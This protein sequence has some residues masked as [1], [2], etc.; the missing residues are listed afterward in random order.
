MN[1]S[2]TRLLGLGLGLSL[3]LLLSLN[4]AE[5]QS[6]QDTP[7]S[8]PVGAED[9]T[10]STEDV[11]SETIPSDDTNEASAETDT[12]DAP[13][14]PEAASLPAEPSDAA[15]AESA[16]SPTTDPPL[17]PALPATDEAPAPVAEP[18]IPPTVNAPE[19]RCIIIVDAA[20]FGIDPIVAGHVTNRMRSVGQSLGY[21]VIERN[22]VIAGAQQTNMPYP[23]SASHLW[24]L[25]A[26][27]DCHRFAFA[28]IGYQANL[29]QF[30]LLVGSL[31]GTGP[32]ESSALSP[33]PLLL[34]SVERELR[35]T[36]VSASEWNE[37]A[38]QES[39]RHMRS[40]VASQL[41]LSAP[42]Q[43]FLGRRF[44]LSLGTESAFGVGD[45]GF[46][47]HLFSLR[48][49]YRLSA[50]SLLGIG[51]S[52]TNMTGRDGRVSNLLPF[53]QFEHRVRFQPH[54]S[55]TMPLR[56]SAGY[57][58]FNGPYIRL[59]IGANFE[60]SETLELALDLLA[61]TFWI[62]PDASAVSLNVG[63][64]VIFRL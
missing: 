6:P 57:L 47:N 31:D 28:Q 18:L 5:A 42:P 41:A 11:S 46:Y 54:H 48:A 43:P 55:A 7:P 45:E 14:S 32:F 37:E 56:V 10:A 52:Y 4:R 26:H 19:D 17:V 1:S 60:I 2:Y 8:V 61:P 16:A 20:A 21:R 27:L 58:P 29:Y 30:R 50:Q 25:T 22:H 35:L 24:Q 59:A 9:E 62:L 64:E 33:A 40:F 51:L 23:P 36:L 38:H 53:V 63:A 13:P 34:G 12:E 3:T 15:V 44:Q 49:D 39:Q